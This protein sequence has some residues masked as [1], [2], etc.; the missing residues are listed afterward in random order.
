MSD[1]PDDRLLEYFD[2]RLTECGDTP[3]GAYWPN[4]T[5]R[6]TRFDVMLDVIN[7]SAEV[8]VVLCDLGCG[9][10][11]LLP[12]IRMRGLRNIAYIGADRSALALSYARA[13]LA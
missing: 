7:V 10:G 2:R 9:T 1:N 11:E 12:H 6:R 5:D 8:P 3:Q 13:K 4:Q